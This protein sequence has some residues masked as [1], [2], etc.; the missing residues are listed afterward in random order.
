VQSLLKIHLKSITF[1][2]VL[3]P[4]AFGGLTKLTVCFYGRMM[5]NRS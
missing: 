2:P 3:S 1:Q 5:I 4:T